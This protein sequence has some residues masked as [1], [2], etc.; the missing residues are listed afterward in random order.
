MPL[1]SIFTTSQTIAAK[2][3][4]LVW[5]A[6]AFLCQVIVVSWKYGHSSDE[7]IIVWNIVNGVFIWL[8]FEKVSEKTNENLYCR[9]WCYTICCSWIR[10]DKF[11]CLLMLKNVQNWVTITKVISKNDGKYWF[12][13]ISPLFLKIGCIFCLAYS[14][15]WFSSKWR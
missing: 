5:W 4:C 13:P 2:T 3:V 9:W 14:E 15:L 1:S 7:M 8:F 11:S 10:F 6:Q 12:I